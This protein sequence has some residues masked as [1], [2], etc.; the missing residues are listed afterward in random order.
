MGVKLRKGVCVCVCVC[1][2]V[3]VCVCVCVCGPSVVGGHRC[4]TSRVIAQS[5]CL[6]L[7]RC[8]A[9]SLSLSLSLSLPVTV[10]VSMS[11]SVC[12]SLCL[13]PIPFVVTVNLGRARQLVIVKSVCGCRVAVWY[14]RE[15][16]FTG[17]RRSRPCALN[18]KTTRSGQRVFVWLFVCLLLFLGEKGG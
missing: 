3:F 18:T 11:L 6:Q 16:L 15:R 4:H 17:S 14:R 10:P 7:C 8:P 12:L 9:L 1:V 5:E 13:F 2:F